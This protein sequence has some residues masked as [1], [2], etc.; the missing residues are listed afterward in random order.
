MRVHASEGELQRHEIALVAAL[1]QRTPRRRRGLGI[2]V[3]CG[4]R[5]EIEIRE[6]HVEPFEK[7]LIAKRGRRHGAADRERHAQVEMIEPPHPIGPRQGA[8]D[9]RHDLDDL[10]DRRWHDGG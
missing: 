7:R 9:E 8:L 5:L 4:H 3:A 1:E 2:R 10:G 6:L